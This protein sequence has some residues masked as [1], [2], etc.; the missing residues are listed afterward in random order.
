MDKPLKCPECNQI[1]MDLKHGNMFVKN[2]TEIDKENIAESVRQCPR[3]KKK[4]IIAVK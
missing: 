1:I 2:S 3:C 4:F